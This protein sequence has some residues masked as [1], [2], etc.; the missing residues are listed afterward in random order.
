MLTSDNVIQ[1][2]IYMKIAY[3][4]SLKSDHPTYKNVGCLLVDGDDIISCGHNKMLMDNYEQTLLNEKKSRTHLMC[5]AE[6]MCLMKK[7]NN[8]ITNSTILYITAIP[9]STCARLIILSGIKNIV[10]PNTIIGSQWIESCEYSLLLLKSNKI[11]IIHINDYI[12]K[13]SGECYCLD[14]NV[15]MGINNP[16]QLCGKSCCNNDDLW[17]FYDKTTVTTI[18]TS[19]INE[20]KRTIVSDDNNKKKR[21]K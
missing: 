15:F 5:H 4:E 19:F 8:N 17:Y 18:N 6:E 16:R 13:H 10:C 20:K 2:N 9:C 7:P 12:F 3:N 14:C 1:H 21:C 11:N